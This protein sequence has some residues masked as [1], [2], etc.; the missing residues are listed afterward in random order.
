MKNVCRCDDKRA[1]AHKRPNDTLTRAHCPSKFSGGSRLLS[2]VSVRIVA[3]LPLDETVEKSPEVLR[4]RKDGGENEEGRAE[5]KDEEE[6]EG[7]GVCSDVGTMRFRYTI[8]ET[9]AQLNFP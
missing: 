6:E 4:K 5:E 9:S 2:A 3:A 8:L 7:K 1:R